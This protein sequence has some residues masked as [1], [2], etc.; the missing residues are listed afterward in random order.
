MFRWEKAI[1]NAET[2]NE[3]TFMTKGCLLPCLRRLLLHLNLLIPRMEPILS[4]GPPEV[5][6]QRGYLERLILCPSP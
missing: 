6:D 3:G 5:S 1:R 4:F 2:V